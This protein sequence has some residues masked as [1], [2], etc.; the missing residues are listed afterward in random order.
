VDRKAFAKQKEA[1]LLDSL[2]LRTG[3]ALRDSRHHRE[4]RAALNE[5]RSM[6]IIGSELL[7]SV[8]TPAAT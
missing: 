8:A 7:L 2:P 1:G 3:I 6:M 5:P 4:L